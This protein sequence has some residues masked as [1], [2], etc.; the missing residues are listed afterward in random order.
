MLMLKSI[1]SNDTDVTLARYHITILNNNIMRYKIMTLMDT[2]EIKYQI[3]ISGRALSESF[4]TKV[5]ADL[6]F[7]KL[8][9]DDRRIAIIVP[10]T[11][12]GRQVI[13]G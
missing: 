1:V 5:A 10:I 13:L 2:P 3:H 9:E 4:T 11:D 12:G 8:S 6:A 7:S